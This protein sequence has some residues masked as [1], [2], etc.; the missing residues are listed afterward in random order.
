MKT[1]FI[2]AKTADLAMTATLYFILAVIA[3]IV[4]NFITK[5][6]ESYTT[7]AGNTKYEKPIWRLILEISANIFFIATTF[8]FIRNAVE[9]VPFPLEGYGGYRHS[10]LTMANTLLIMNMTVIVF[11]TSLMDK[12]RALND[13]LFSKYQDAFWFPKI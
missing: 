5:A 11:Q 2:L 8:W 9:A 6:Y 1:A 10:R 13:Q 7:P 4:L 12:I 3:S